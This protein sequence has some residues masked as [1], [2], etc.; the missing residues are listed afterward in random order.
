MLGWSTGMT[1]LRRREE[2]AVW[3]REEEREERDGWGDRER[4]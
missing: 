3:R 2:R 1:K 4:G